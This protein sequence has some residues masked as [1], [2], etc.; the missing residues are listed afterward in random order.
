MSLSRPALV[1]APRQRIPGRVW[2]WGLGG[3]VVMVK[4]S[5]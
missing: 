2:F 4:D 1:F 3:F 5:M